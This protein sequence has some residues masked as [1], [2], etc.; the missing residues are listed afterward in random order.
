[1]MGFSLLLAV[2]SEQ[3]HMCVD[4]PS[5]DSPI[6]LES[7]EIEEGDEGALLSSSWLSGSLETH[8]NSLLVI[9]FEH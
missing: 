5:T 8:H 9:Y 2:D 3:T 7:E 6:L 4:S 1:M